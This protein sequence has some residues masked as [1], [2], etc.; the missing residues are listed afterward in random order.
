[1]LE[2]TEG[3]LERCRDAEK[4]PRKTKIKD[5]RKKEGSKN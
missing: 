3:R 4:R 5:I 2:T 1:M